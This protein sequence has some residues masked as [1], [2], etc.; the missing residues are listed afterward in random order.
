MELAFLIDGCIEDSDRHTFFGDVANGIPKSI[1]RATG[2]KGKNDNDNK[3]DESNAE[4][5]A[6]AESLAI[7]FS[8]ESSATIDMSRAVADSSSSESRRKKKDAN[9][10]YFFTVPG[11]PTGVRVYLLVL[12]IFSAMLAAVFVGTLQAMFPTG[13]P[14]LTVPFIFATW[15][16]LL[17]VRDENCA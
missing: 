12:G 7:L 6:V 4:A 2:E 3:A 9:F 16:F 10:S 1:G 17:V 5:A 13:V 11:L 8:K 14:V 15:G